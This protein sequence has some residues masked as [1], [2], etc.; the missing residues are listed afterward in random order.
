MAL[1]DIYQK[2]SLVQI[3]SGYKSGTLYSVVPNTADGDFTVTGDAEGEATRVNK[4][5]LIESVAA[6]VPRLNYDPSNPKDPHLLL[7]PSRTNQITKSRDFEGWQ[8]LGGSETVTNNDAIA[9]NGAN[10]AATIE[11]TGSDTSTLRF[12]TSYSNF[13]TIRSASIYIKKLSGNPTVSFGITDTQDSITP[14]N[15]WVRYTKDNVTPTDFGVPIFVDIEVSGVSGDKVAVW[16][17]QLEEG[18]YST[19]LIE[20][21][22]S[23][24]TRTADTCG[25]AG[26]GTIIKAEGSLF[27]DLTTSNTDN[28]KRISITDASDSN[29]NIFIQ[30][31]G[32]AFAVQVVSGGTTVYSWGFSITLSDR[33]KIALRYKDGDSQLYYNGTQQTATT[34]SGTWFTDGLLDTFS[35]NQGSFFNFYGEIYSTMLFNEALSDSELQTLTS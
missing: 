13:S 34:T 30:L 16:G 25:D 22:G 31:L 23:E 14:T 8:D 6:N 12:F 18:T 29:N 11:K 2:A 19:S 7:E 21:S 3:P 32:T 15:E 20:T 24:A 35:L 9:P 5:G 17:A 33:H 1:S 4:D 26:D 27:V 28:F 10:T